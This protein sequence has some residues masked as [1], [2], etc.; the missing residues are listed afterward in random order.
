LLFFALTLACSIVA[1]PAVSAPV[2]PPAQDLE[3][4]KVY[5]CI[6]SYETLLP[7]D[8]YA[9]L[10]KYYFQRKHYRQMVEML[11][12]SAHWANKDAQYTLGLIYYNGDTPGVPANR[13]LAIAWLALAAERKNPAY[14]QAYDAI[15][16][17]STPEE[18]QAATN[19][20][21][22]MKLEYGDKV[23]G[24]R[25]L[26]QFNRGIY[27]LDEAANYGGPVLLSGFSPYP[28]QA[29]AAVKKL[30]DIAD[31]DFEGLQ[32]TVT[33]G[34]LKIEDRL[35]DENTVGKNP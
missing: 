4:A 28:E 19:I 25:A 33:V 9:C 21:N 20:S 14:L 6:R 15:S 11:E 27:T 7:G 31:H 16:L 13:P 30:H 23:A 24:L 18:I 29:F 32:G 2:A 34:S 35:R 12:E 26:R 8:Y 22:K 5:G 3:S 17:R 1:I 10:A